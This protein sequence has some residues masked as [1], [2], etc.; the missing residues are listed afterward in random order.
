MSEVL[1]LDAAFARVDA[2]WRPKIVADV[3]DHELKVVK[4]QGVFP[5]HS[6]AEVDELF[7]VW[8][9]EFRLEFRDRVLT[10]GPGQAAV[11]PRGVEH[12]TAA[13]AEAQVLIFEQRGVVNTGD[14]RDPIYT[15]P[16]GAR[17]QG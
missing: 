10:L 3:N 8:R 6:H 16:V 5:W 13:D 15:A 2:H 7:V 17:L 1:D 14:V 11:A 9:G 12:R 4:V